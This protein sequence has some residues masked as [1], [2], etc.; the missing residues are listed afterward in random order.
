[1]NRHLT[2]DE[3]IDRQYGLGDNSHIEDCEECA[4][5]LHQMHQRKSEVVAAKEVPAEFFNAQRRKIYA[6]LDEKPR[7]R[8]MWAPALA[9]ACLLAIG[10]FVYR[11]SE[12]VAPRADAGDAQ[13]FSEVYSM[14][15]STEPMAAAP[16][17]ALLEDNQ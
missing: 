12:P 14:E 8:G 4:A 15:Q 10:I 7:S 6:R 1:M 2:D 5:R 17:H 9:A 11:P 3:L 13:L 16:I